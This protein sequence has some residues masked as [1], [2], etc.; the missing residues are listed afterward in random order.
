MRMRKKAQGQPWDHRPILHRPPG[1]RL[2]RLAFPDCPSG[3]RTGGKVTQALPIGASVA[4]A[5]A[6]LPIPPPRGTHKEYA[7]RFIRPLRSSPSYAAE[8]PPKS[9]PA[10]R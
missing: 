6:W 1:G 5:V 9:S 7:Q 4:I 10:R 3:W 2:K 8:R